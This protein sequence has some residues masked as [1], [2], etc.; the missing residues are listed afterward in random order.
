MERDDLGCLCLVVR[1]GEEGVLLPPVP[2]SVQLRES[3][4]TDEEVD[5]DKTKG[6]GRRRDVRREETR[7]RRGGEGTGERGT[8]GGERVVD[9]GDDHRVSHPDESGR[10]ES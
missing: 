4:R 5:L 7:E 9:G 10:A 2:H 1:G 3:G 8:Y 6:A